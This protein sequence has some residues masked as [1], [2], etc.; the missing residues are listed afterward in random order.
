MKRITLNLWMLGAIALFSA[1]AVPA[2]AACALQ[3]TEQ[4]TDTAATPSVIS[5]PS[6]VAMTTDRVG[7][8]IAAEHPTS[9][10]ARII[11]ENGK[12]FLVLDQAFKTD[13]GPDL[14]V[15]LHRENPPQTYNAESYI[16]L[17]VLQ[18]VSG[19]QRYA[20]PETVDVAT[21]QSAVIWCRQ[22]NATFGY[23]PLTDP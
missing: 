21:L 11:T 1:T 3:N 15:L 6:T 4:S 19:E 10:S 14:F 18:T 17:G 2:L 12:R 16:S 7:Q 9:G 22:F 5:S 13:E 23:A 8:F 20:I